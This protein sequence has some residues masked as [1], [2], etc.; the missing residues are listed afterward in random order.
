LTLAFWS[1]SLFS[2]R[3][4]SSKAAPNS[5]SGSKSAGL[6]PQPTDCKHFGLRL[7]KSCVPHVGSSK[8]RA[9]TADSVASSYSA[10]REGS[11]QAKS[12][13]STQSGIAEPHRGPIKAAR[14]GTLA[15]GCIAGSMSPTCG[16]LQHPGGARP[17][18]AFVRRCGSPARSAWLGYG[19]GMAA[20]LSRI[21]GICAVILPSPADSQATPL[22]DT[23]SFAAHSLRLM[24]R[25]GA[26]KECVLPQLP[27]VRLPAGCTAAAWPCQKR[28]SSNASSLRSMW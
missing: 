23:H 24:L 22:S 25:E 21:S 5:S 4:C 18:R 28:S 3:G 20:S 9:H 26:A 15:H 11:L 8:R 14:S 19:A 7:R 13:S 16:C 17:W 1:A 27:L 6:S 2:L 10:R 12:K